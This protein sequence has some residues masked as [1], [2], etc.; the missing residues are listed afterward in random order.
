MVL[1]L[2]R[3]TT[4]WEKPMSAASTVGKEKGKGPLYLKIPMPNKNVCN[5][6]QHEKYW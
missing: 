2:T 6:M 4:D 3:L 5:V 1:A